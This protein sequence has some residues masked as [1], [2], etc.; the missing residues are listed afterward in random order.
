MSKTKISPSKDP[1]AGAA[2][3]LHV[4][5]VSEANDL[6]K[7]WTALARKCVQFR[8]AQHYKKVK[9]QET[10]KP[11]TSFAE[12][13]QVVFDQSKSTLFAMIRIV[14]TLDGV[15]KD[16]DMEEIGKEKSEILT[17]AVKA[18][19]EITPELTEAAKNASARELRKRIPK[20]R[21]VDEKKKAA[22]ST[23]TLGPYRVAVKTADQFE[24][25]LSTA[26]EKTAGD[27]GEQTDRAIAFIATTFFAGIKATEGA[28]AQEVA[29]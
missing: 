25:A 10:G 4:E 14:R 23:R 16:E 13:A 28:K 15:V 7:R 20:L 2:L 19:E 12:W 5:I 26:V 24:L 6:R 9:N 11:F 22:A 1:A 27:S 29:A 21:L 17:E 3:K 18:G 8:V